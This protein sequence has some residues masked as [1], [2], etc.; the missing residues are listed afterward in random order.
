MGERNAGAHELAED[1]LA[2]ASSALTVRILEGADFGADA[3]R[4]PRAPHRHAYHELFWTRSGEG[5]HL[6][7]GEPADVRPG[8]VTVIGRGQV[9]VLARAHDVHGAVI[10]F[11]DELLLG[12]PTGRANPAWLIGTRTAH[13][14]DVPAGDVP[15]LE[16]TIEALAEELRRPPDPRSADVQRHLLCTVLLWVDR[17]YE[18]S[19]IEYRDSDD[20]A[21]ELY[22]RFVELLERD[23][24]RHHDAVHYADELRVPQAALSKALAQATGHTTKEL[25]TDRRMLEAARLLRFTALTVGEIAYRAGYSDQLYFS[26][27]FRR[28]YGT[29]PSAYRH[30]SA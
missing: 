9:H 12:D 2:T 15:R 27:A 13:T 18:D 24:A 1:R 8:T 4:G 23:F 30:Q 26:R 17:W 3:A 29:A 25:I 16:H 14:V 28:H 21:L 6:I 11:G 7:D 10:R 19:R 20:V 5:H 22:R